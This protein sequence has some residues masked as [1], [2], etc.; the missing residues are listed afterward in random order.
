[1]LNVS[2]CSMN[3]TYSNTTYTATKLSNKATIGVFEVVGVKLSPSS[4]PL[5]R[6]DS[7]TDCVTSA[8]H[9]LLSTPP[10]FDTFDS[11]NKNRQEIQNTKS[12]HSLDFRNAIC[13][14][15]LIFSTFL[16]A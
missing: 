4:W 6:T 7:V 12:V 3:G 13:A 1:M 2:R 14:S 15:S 9:V 5:F 10:T 16:Y 11:I 8:T